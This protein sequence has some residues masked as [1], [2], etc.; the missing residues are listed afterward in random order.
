M[1]EQFYI[2]KAEIVNDGRR[3]GRSAQTARCRKL[4]RQSRG[5][6]ICIDSRGA[7]FA[8]LLIHHLQHTGTIAGFGLIAMDDKIFVY[9]GTVIMEDVLCSV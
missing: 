6:R 2:L 9:L 7:F 4:F 1:R 3:W 8:D 5:F